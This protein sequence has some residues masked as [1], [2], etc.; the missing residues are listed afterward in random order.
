MAIQ[1]N[2]IYRIVQEGLA[3]ACKHGKSERVRV[4]L[5]QQGSGL[6]VE[7]QDWGVGFDPSRIGE[8]CFGLEGIRERVR[9]LGGQSTIESAPGKGARIAVEL[10]L[11]VREQVA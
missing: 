5:V 11:V 10:P 4:A 9:L 8:Q 2:A 3:N 6:R 7:V 1:E